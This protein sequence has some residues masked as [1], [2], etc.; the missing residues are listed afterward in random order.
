ME[1]L[2]E[3]QKRFA[4]LLLQGV[5]QTNA[6]KQAGYKPKN[7]AIAAACSSALRRNPKI[8]SYMGEIAKKATEQTTADVAEIVNKFWAI[9]QADITEICEFDANGVYLRD[10]KSLP[11]HLTYAIQE[12]SER[13]G[14]DG[15]KRVYVKL[16]DKQTALARLGEYLKM[17]APQ[18]NLNQLNLHLH[19]Y[20][21]EKES[22]AL[23]T[24]N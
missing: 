15:K 20:M 4:D 1:H 7:D 14:A 16:H 2:S 6:Y 24:D 21:P 9:A 18:I 12:V 13:V 17:F 3:K 23:N 19:V 5:D 8:L 10:S 11:K 22:I